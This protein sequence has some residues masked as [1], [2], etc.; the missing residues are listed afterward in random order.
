M[1]SL[2]Y[3]ILGQ[4]AILSVPRKD[5]EKLAWTRNNVVDFRVISKALAF[6]FLAVI[7]PMSHFGRV[8]L[9][10]RLVV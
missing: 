6:T 3:D 10:N 5:Y 7:R 1:E 9:R 4:D 2:L 8:D